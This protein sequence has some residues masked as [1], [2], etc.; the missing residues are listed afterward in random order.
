MSNIERMSYKK[1]DHFNED[2]F[3]NPEP[4]R[5]PAV[6]RRGGLLR[7]LRARLG[8]DESVWSTW[9]KHVENSLYPPPDLTRPSISWIGHSSFLLCL[10]GMN[11]LTDPIFSAR[12]SPVGFMG[13]RRVRAPGLLVESLP[14][15]DLILLSHNHYDH[16]DIPSLRLIRR[17]F[18]EAKIVTSLGNAD[19]LARKGLHRAVEL[20]WWEHLKFNNL[21]ITATP[22]RHFAARTLWDRNKTLWVGFMLNYHGRSIYFAGDTGYTNAFKEIYSRLGAPDLA[23]LPIG[24]YQP[25]DM[26]ASVHMD[27]DEAVQA[28]LD[29]QARRAVG[30]H[31]GTFQ[32][33]GEPIDEPSKKLKA[34]LDAKDIPADRFIVLDIGETDYPAA[35]FC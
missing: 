32:L 3:F 5:Y 18:P 26:M 34:A 21:Q 2:H 17:R 24:A 11:I 29:L 14:R 12:C 7:L 27:P 35:P 30:M 23:L 16:M 19:F 22:A 4:A 28:F 8:R 20:D 15:I 9:P 10:G 25:R 6:A 1:S 31:F 13:P 33:T